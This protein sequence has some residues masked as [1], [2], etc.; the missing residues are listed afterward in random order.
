M[1]EAKSFLSHALNTSGAYFI[2]MR[3]DIYWGKGPFQELSLPPESGIAFYVNKFELTDPYPWKVPSSYQVLTHEEILAQRMCPSL[4]LTEDEPLA[5]LKFAEVFQQIQTEIRLGALQK[6]VPVVTQTLIPNTCAVQRQIVEAF[7]GAQKPWYGYAYWNEERGFAGASPEWLFCQKDKEL[8]TMAL[9]GTASLEEESIFSVDDK[10]IKEHEYVAQTLVE[11]LGDYGVVDAKSREILKL[12]KLIHF[13]TKIHVH[14]ESFVPLNEII[15]RLHPTPALGCLP[16][17]S[18]TSTLMK[19]WR[20]MLHTP[21]YFGSPFG[22]LCEGQFEC[23]VAIR[24]LHW[25]KQTLSLPSG[26]GIIEDSRMTQEWNELRLKR[27]A[28]LRIL[29]SIA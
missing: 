2:N 18:H 26:C 3:G 22:L 27:A 24:G 20:E 9:A 1:E 29:Q 11:K 16:R 12:D 4:E 21:E 17:T 5:P 7:L 19:K 10:E 6:S 14:M 25:D 13:L 23:L 8:Y 15:R 28:V